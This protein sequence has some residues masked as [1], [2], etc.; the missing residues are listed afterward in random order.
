M[1]K[2][3]FLTKDSNGAGEDHTQRSVGVVPEPGS[4]AAAWPPQPQQ[5]ARPRERTFKKG[6]PPMQERT[7]LQSL[8]HTGQGDDQGTQGPGLTVHAIK[9]WDKRCPALSPVEMDLVWF[10]M[11]VLK[12]EGN[13]FGAAMEPN[14]QGKGRTR[15]MDF[16]NLAEKLS[17]RKD[18]LISFPVDLCSNI[19]QTCGLACCFTCTE[20]IQTR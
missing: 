6:R 17:A 11:E 4:Q 7:A 19:D 5:L 18:W 16:R 15:S 9:I 12:L 10:T 8:G 14:T 1:T 13:S 20:A 3:E 2:E